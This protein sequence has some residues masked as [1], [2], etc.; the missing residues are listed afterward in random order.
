M[1]VGTLN[2]ANSEGLGWGVPLVS[3]VSLV[4][5]FCLTAK[6]FRL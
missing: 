6:L 5:W 1:L 4:L 2:S 3:R